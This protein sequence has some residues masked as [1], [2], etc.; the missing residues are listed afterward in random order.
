ME[1][2]L[3]FQLTHNLKKGFC[4][5]V[6]IYVAVGVS[7]ATGFALSVILVRSLTQEEFGIY[8]LIGSIILIG[9]Y[10]CSLGLEST[11]LRFAAEF[12]AIGYRGR[13]NKLIRWFMGMRFAA[14]LIFVSALLVFQKRLSTLFNFPQ[15]M[16]A[17]LPLVGVILFLQSMNSLW[18][19]AFLSARMD[20]VTDSINKIAVSLLKLLGFAAVLW[21]GYGIP[22]IVGVWATVLFSSVACYSYVNYCWLKKEDSWHTNE[23]NGNSITSYRKRISRF[24]FFNF[25]A[26]N[27]NIFKDISIDNFIIAHYLGVKDIALYGLASILVLFVGNFNPASVLR[28]VLNPI[29]VSRYIEKGDSGELVQANTFL[30]KVIIISTLPLYFLLII[31]GDKIIGIVYSPDYLSVFSALVYLCCFFFFIGLC[32]TFNMLMNTLE[33]NELFLTSGVFS[34][35]N[36]IMD[37]IL[38]PRYGINGAAIATGSAGLLQFFFYWFAFKWYVKLN[39]KFPWRALTQTIVNIVPMAAFVFIVKPHI[40]N[41]VLLIITGVCSGLIYLSF[42]YMNNVFN[43]QEKSLLVTAS[44]K[45]APLLRMRAV[46]P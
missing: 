16:I 3:A 37:I 25:F 32:Y 10:I 22:G 20:Q 41:L 40:E 1:R 44:P 33:K 30:L 26:I 39:I 24:A 17:L 14:V 21:M 35:Y 31:L 38:V 8:R 45:L 28:G 27:V 11:F 7:M 5:G 43:N 18:G 9:T 34:I 42:L 36:L 19:T 4:G 13:L 29:F 15:Q 12:I 23:K 2:P 6:S 46:N